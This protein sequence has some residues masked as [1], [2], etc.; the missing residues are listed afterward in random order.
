[1][2]G[3]A[4]LDAYNRD[5][6]IMQ[7]PPGYY[8]GLTSST[9]P[10]QGQE[11]MLP[12]TSASQLPIMNQQHPLGLLPS[13]DATQ[14][15]NLASLPP[16]M[17]DYAIMQALA[18][19]TPRSVYTESPFGLHS[20]PPVAAPAP[21]NQGMSSWGWQHAPSLPLQQELPAIATHEEHIPSLP[22]NS[23]LTDASAFLGSF[24]EQD[25]QLIHDPSPFTT[26]PSDMTL[27][28]DFWSEI[29]SESPSLDFSMLSQSTTDLLPPLTLSDSSPESSPSPAPSPSLDHYFPAQPSPP[30]S[31][32]SSASKLPSA[33]ASGSKRQCS[34]CRATSTPLWRRDPA[35]LKPL[36]NACGLYLQQRNKLRPQELIDADIDDDTPS[37]ASVNFTG[38]ECSH[39]HTRQTSV[40][41]RSKSGAQLCNACGVYSRLR[42]KDRPLSLKRNKIKPR[43]KHTSK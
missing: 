21:S 10:F 17:I 7:L 19:I 26:S 32:P 11:I 29:K 36:C 39:C 15:P 41:R 20:A 4:T 9:L 12:S 35:T 31:P 33:S 24:P 6:Y 27:D 30:R 1:M 34:H 3:R 28:L 8:N 14:M 40:W 38:P 43:S 2:L 37:D 23:Y 13:Y 18:L 16:A 5:N 42:G 22:Q 25:K